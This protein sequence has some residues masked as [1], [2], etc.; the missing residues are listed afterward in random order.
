[1]IRAVA[2]DAVGTLIHPDPPAADVYAAVGRQF[3]SRLDLPEIRR[4]FMTAFR[5]Q[6]QLDWDN[7]LTTSEERELRRW[8]AIVAEVLDDVRDPEGCFAAL[9]EHFSRPDAWACEPGAEALLAELRRR[10][11][12][13]ALASNYD[14]RLR[15]VAAGLEPLRHVT[16]FVISSEV[17][18]RKPAPAFFAQLA[19]VLQLPA[20]EIL[21]VGDDPVND[22]EGG[23]AAGLQVLLCDRPL[24]D[25]KI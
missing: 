21:L 7:D 11:L 22:V 6:E 3:G 8:R 13:I 5:R 16:H 4:R 14:R 20:G 10:G 24:V 15:S 19:D 2:F 12:P 9:Y 17:G 23:R 1:M 18:W 25:L